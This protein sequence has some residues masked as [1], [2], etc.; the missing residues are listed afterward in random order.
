MLLIQSAFLSHNHQ[1]YCSLRKSLYRLLLLAPP[2]VHSYLA[3]L[4]YRLS[5][6][7]AEEQAEMA[8]TLCESIEEVQL[9]ICFNYEEQYGDGSFLCLTSELPSSGSTSSMGLKAVQLSA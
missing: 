2:H 5:F 7:F 9:L 4:Y 8:T 3:Y 6:S 1:D